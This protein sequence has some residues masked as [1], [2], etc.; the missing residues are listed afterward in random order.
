[1]SDRYDKDLLPSHAVNNLVRET[2]DDQ[3]ASSGVR[4][5]GSASQR[6]VRGK[7]ERP[8]DGVEKV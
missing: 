8:T 4:G 2:P 3:A 6:A 7:I 1:M 5:D